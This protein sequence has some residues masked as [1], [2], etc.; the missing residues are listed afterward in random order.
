MV[1][2]YPPHHFQQGHG[3]RHITMR[4]HGHGHHTT[5]SG[6]NAA[7][8]NRPGAFDDL[9]AIERRYGVNLDI[10]ERQSWEFFD[11]AAYPQAGIASLNFF[12]N[13][14]GQGTG[15]GGGAK[16]ASDTNMTA[17]GQL[18]A[19]QMFLIRKIEV[20]IEPTTPSVTA[21]NPAVGGGGE[22]GPLL[23]N[24]VWNI[25]RSGNLTLTVG[26]KNYIELGPLGKFPPSSWMELQAALSDATTAAGNQQTRAAFAQFKGRGFHLSPYDV[27]LIPTQNFGVQLAWPE[28][29]Q[30]ITNPARLFVHLIGTF[31]RK[32]Q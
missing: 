21:Q 12:Q 10:W 22:V 2:H 26:Q 9:S 31:Y 28:G 19:N 32:A 8:A 16:T 17:S 25:G 5:R 3:G 30:A 14:K 23:I 20:S 18:P 24:D 27:M 29:L 15:F 1:H 11:S 13:P 7:P 6:H 4:Q